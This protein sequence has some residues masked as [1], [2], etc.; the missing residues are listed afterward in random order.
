MH[1][2]SKN[3]KLQLCDPIFIIGTGRSGTHWVANT[4]SSH[5][6]LSVGL[7]VE[8]R[9]GRSKSMAL[10]QTCQ[11][12]LLPKVIRNYRF[13]KYGAFPR[14]LVD[15]AHPNIWIAESLATRFPNSLFIGTQRNVYATVASMIRCNPVNAWHY[16][17]REFPV[18]NPFL[19]I[20]SEIAPDYESLSNAEKC[21]LRWL[22]HRDRMGQL[23]KTLDHRLLVVDY[24]KLMDDVHSTLRRISEFL[25]L[26]SPLATPP[27]QT[28]SRS[29]WREVLSEEDIYRIDSMI[30]EWDIGSNRF[31]RNRKHAN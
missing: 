1:F 28:E 14:R 3:H 9:F 2:Q 25:G 19:G 23:R 5:P 6:E 8:P 22:S 29:K 4:L 31:P 26:K 21:T 13:A 12:K 18:P 24:E 17:W 16:R 15:K 11:K 7:E 20:T 27:I 10:D 30:R